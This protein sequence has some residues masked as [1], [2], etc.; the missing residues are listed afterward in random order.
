MGKTYTPVQKA[1]M[2]CRITELVRK[3]GRMTLNQL[4]RVTGA[5]CQTVRRYVKKAAECGDLY[6]AGTKGIFPSKEDFRTWSEKPSDTRVER[7]LKIEEGLM[8]P[9][10]RDNNVICTECRNSEAMRRL[11]AFYRGNYRED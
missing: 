7:F 4:E 5:S 1:E 11:M 6:L 2:Q 10:D 9:Y 8:S 3:N